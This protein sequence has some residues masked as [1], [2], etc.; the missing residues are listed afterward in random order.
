MISCSYFAFNLDAETKVL[1]TSTFH[2][3]HQPL[4]VYALLLDFLHVCFSL[5][6][7]TA[8]AAWAAGIDIYAIGVTDEVDEAELAGISSHPQIQGER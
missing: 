6:I 7:P 4:F 1:C 5:Q 3:Y 2:I 8:E